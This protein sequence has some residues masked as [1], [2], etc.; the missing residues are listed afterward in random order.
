MLNKVLSLIQR[1]LEMH[2]IKA[3]AIHAA[4]QP[5]EI[6]LLFAPDAPTVKLTRFLTKCGVSHD[7]ETDDALTSICIYF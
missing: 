2:N 1:I 7:I 3:K 5:Q 4:E 6:I